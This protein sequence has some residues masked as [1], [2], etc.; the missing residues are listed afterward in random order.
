MELKQRLP[1][2]QAQCSPEWGGGTAFRGTLIKSCQALSSIS[3]EW[4]APSLLPA[5]LQNP[6]S[7]RRGGQRALCG[8]PEGWAARAPR[9]CVDWCGPPHSQASPVASSEVRS[10]SIATDCLARAFSRK[11][12]VRRWKQKYFVNCKGAIQ[13]RRRSIIISAL[14]SCSLHQHRILTSLT[15]WLRCILTFLVP[16]TQLLHE[17]PAAPPPRP[18]PRASCPL[19]LLFSRPGRPSE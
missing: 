13:A 19:L 5:S 14:F 1:L 16:Q 4:L 8:A 12:Q 18:P 6:T 2:T 9:A 17:L 11:G 7:Q 10:G 3:S 15:L